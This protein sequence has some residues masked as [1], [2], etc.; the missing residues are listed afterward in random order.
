MTLA[1]ACPTGSWRRAFTS[2]WSAHMA[3]PSRQGWNPLIASFRYYKEKFWDKWDKSTDFSPRVQ[4]AF[5]ISYAA[6]TEFVLLLNRERNLFNCT[7]NF[8]PLVEHL[9]KSFIKQMHTVP[10]IK[11]ICLCYFLP[12]I[13]WSQL[14]MTF[15]GLR[16][17]YRELWTFCCFW[18]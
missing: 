6:A 12:N 4:L 7:R 3:P 17:G 14:N 13:L 18:I 5:R 16:L 8:G 2:T 1:S 15:Q 11:M 10:K 9:K